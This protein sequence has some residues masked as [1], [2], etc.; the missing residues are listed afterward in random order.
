MQNGVMA[1][2]IV[3]IAPMNRSV[4]SL[5]VKFV[6]DIDSKEVIFY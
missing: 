2:M 1:T 3:W 5:L 6:V 4:V